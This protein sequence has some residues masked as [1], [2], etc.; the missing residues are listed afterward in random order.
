MEKYKKLFLWWQT[1]RGLKPI[2]QFSDS[3]VYC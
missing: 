3:F 1:R 2:S